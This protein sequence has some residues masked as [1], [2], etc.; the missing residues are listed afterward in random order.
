LDFGEDNDTEFDESDA[1]VCDGQERVTGFE[2]M[3]EDDREPDKG[4]SA[5]YFQQDG[6]RNLVFIFVDGWKKIGFRKNGAE[7]YFMSVVV[8][9]QLQE[10]EYTGEQS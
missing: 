7:D 3:I 2:N 1:Q 4:K 10:K 6:Q 5:E 9:D 8:R